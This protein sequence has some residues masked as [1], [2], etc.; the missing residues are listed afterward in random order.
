MPHWIIY[1]IFAIASIVAICLYFL[2]QQQRV[3]RLRKEQADLEKR[4]AQENAWLAEVRA[5]FLEYGPVP[6]PDAMAFYNVEFD[7]VFGGTQEERNEDI[8]TA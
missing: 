5:Y 1:L 3:Q 2:E 6:S 7:G 8:H 4:H